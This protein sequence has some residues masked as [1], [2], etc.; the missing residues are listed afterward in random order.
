MGEEGK[1][2]LDSLSFS[3]KEETLAAMVAL[4]ESLLRVRSP[5][6]KRISIINFKGGV[7]KTTLA[8]ELAAGLARY[9]NAARILIV[10]VDHQSS[11]SIVCMG[12]TKW[13]KA[14]D[15][16]STVAQVF[17]SFGGANPMPGDEIIHATRLNPGLYPNIQIVPAS[18]SLDN[19]EIE[20]TSAHQG[21]IDSEWNKRTLLCKWL[22]E[23]GTD[24]KFDYI[25][26][27]C[28]PATKIVSQN[29][30]AASH[31]YVIPVVPEAVMERGAPHLFEMVKSSIDARLK[32]L[33]KIGD[34]RRTFVPNT[35]LVGV[36]I[37]RIQEHGAAYS[38]YTDDHTRHL[39]SLERTWNDDLIKP[40]IALGTG[41]S[42]SLAAGR[43]VY[44]YAYNQNIGR[45]GIDDAYRALTDELKKRIDAL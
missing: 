43:P 30:I 12:P 42:A 15:A 16:N 17:S 8:F 10:D 33:S 37:T 40:Y 29:A 9:Y 34:R 11:L 14:V 32:A 25:L 21:G 13:Q 2:D 28:P 18:L 19:I 44:D 1:S 26:F 4:A 3:D 31:G 35:K 38:G 39:G 27:D 36:V 41:V 5:M 45:R 6:A 7:G 23:T 20:L 24:K 22:E